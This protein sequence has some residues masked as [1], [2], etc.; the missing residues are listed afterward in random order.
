MSANKTDML[1]FGVLRLKCTE[2][3]HPNFLCVQL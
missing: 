1:F 3:E 2:F